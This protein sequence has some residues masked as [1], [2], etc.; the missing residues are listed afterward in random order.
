MQP[1]FFINKLRKSRK[2]IKAPQILGSDDRALIHFLMFLSIQSNLKEIYMG[3]SM[4]KSSTTKQGLII[5]GHGSRRESWNQRFLDLVDLV[6]ADHSIQERFSAGVETGF[7]ENADPSL[8]DAALTLQKKGANHLSVIPLFLSASVHLSEDL[9]LQIA[10]LNEKNCAVELIAGPALPETIGANAL[11]RAKNFPTPPNKAGVVLIYYGSS[12][13]EDRWNQL[14]QTVENFLF[15]KGYVHVDSAPIGH[16]V[17]SRC[18]PTHDA[19]VRT[20]KECERAIVIPLLVSISSYQQETIPEAIARLSHE[21]Q[22]RT[23][24]RA[25]SILPDP[26]L[27]DWLIH[28]ALHISKKEG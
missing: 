1:L 2:M 11:R 17:D 21:Q 4:E 28:S 8:H 23:D 14:I 22:L 16:V 19:I 13:Y 20:L 9:P 6:R 25:S 26:E 7:L 27:T 24:Y 3:H 12:R 15:S 10:A 18:E 5:C